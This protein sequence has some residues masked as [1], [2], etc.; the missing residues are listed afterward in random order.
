MVGTHS[1]RARHAQTAY[2]RPKPGPG[3]EHAAWVE[4]THV[5]LGWAYAADGKDV[6]KIQLDA[7]SQGR[8]SCNQ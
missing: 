4:Y 1:V 2:V 7:H 6:Q 3:L 8:V 5:E